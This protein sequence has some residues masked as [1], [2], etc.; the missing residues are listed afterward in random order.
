MRPLPNRIITKVVKTNL[1]L[2]EKQ[3]ILKP[4]SGSDNFCGKTNRVNILD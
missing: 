4:L 3:N 2:K 1:N